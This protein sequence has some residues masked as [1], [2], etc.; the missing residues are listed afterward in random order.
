MTER[1]LPLADG[2]PA[3]PFV[4]FDDDRDERSS[5]PD[6]R[7]RCFA[8][9]RPAPRAL[10]HQEA[11]CL[12]SAFPVCPTFQ[13]WARREAAHS[14]DG[15]RPAPATAVP[16]SSD[17]VAVPPAIVAPDLARAAAAAVH[18]DDHVD[19]DD[20][21]EDDRERG[22]G[23]AVPADEVWARPGAGTGDFSADD[24]A[25]DSTGALAGAAAGGA[26]ADAADDAA[27][28][29]D[30]NRP[31]RPDGLAQ[32]N[33]PRD[34]AAP[35]PWLASD[36]A[37]RRAQIDAEPPS[38]LG[39]RAEPGQGL[40]GSAADRMAGGPVPAAASRDRV[41]DEEWT[42]AAGSSARGRHAA[43]SDY[44]DAIDE[45]DEDDDYGREEEPPRRST[46]RPR[47]YNQHLGGPEGPDWERPRRFEAYPTIRTRVGLPKIRVPSIALM[48]AA[49]VVLALALFF[50]PGM[51]NLGGGTAS[52]PSASPS[53]GAGPSVSVAPTVP[54]APT[55]IVY[56][57]KKG[58][59]LS[60]IAT[61]NGLTLDELL[62]ANPT[63]KDPNKIGLGQQIIIPT[64]S[65]PPPD[66][67]GQ[68]T[69]P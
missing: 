36:E 54:P 23:G 10:A 51:L 50:L 12:S 18:A 44:Q 4:A 45:G 3:C 22:A 55:P 31:D 2:A 21:L 64:P 24:S 13:D 63:I 15:G 61:A 33:P 16:I 48:A 69:A 6:H 17:R 67:V 11:Y 30:P 57:I 60:K 20:D 35:P 38:F 62:A 28:E 5:V 14:R 46:R 56:T 53:S 59:T 19:P 27:A 43:A 41:A 65:E 66:E 9:A 42:S 29:W 34:W 7:H 68:S 47:A 37:K 8:E 39:R 52:G 49:I 26:A 1:G 40:A 58:D 32:R 25:G